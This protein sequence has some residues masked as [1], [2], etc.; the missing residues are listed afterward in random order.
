MVVDECLIVV[1]DEAQHVEELEPG[2]GV[3]SSPRDVQGLES[4]LGLGLGSCN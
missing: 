3:V 1:V 2:L 4:G